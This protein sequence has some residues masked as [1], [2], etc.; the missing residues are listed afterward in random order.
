MITNPSLDLNVLLNN[1][2]TSYEERILKI[3]TAFQSSE[4][5]S[6]TTHSLF[7]NIHSTLTDL[8]KERN[9][10]Y[11]TL[12]ENLAKNESLRKK[13][14]NELMSGILDALDQKERE[15]EARF[16]EFIEAQK[17]T[18][19]QLKNSLL[20]I[21]DITSV[22]AG[23][24][25]V[26]LREQL[27]QISVLQEARKDRVLKTFIDFQKLHNRIMECIENLLGK[28][29]HIHIQDIKKLKA[30]IISEIN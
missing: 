3:Q 9:T 25:I 8:R 24:S 16:L 13:D 21:K 22:D 30:R 17:E 11:I 5:I 4:N 18:A 20:G 29:G 15:T 23:E 2:V 19:Q 27:A 10:L 12:C 26:S 6:E 7:D 14:Y 28:G 1:I